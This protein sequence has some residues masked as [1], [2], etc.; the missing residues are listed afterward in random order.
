MLD[1][2]V[3]DRE[4]VPVGR[5]EGQICTKLSA[6]TLPGAIESSYTVPLTPP[7]AAATRA[8]GCGA[9]VAVTTGVTVLPEVSDAL[10]DPANATEAL[11]VR[12]R[13]QAATSPPR[14]TRD[15]RVRAV[16]DAICFCSPEWR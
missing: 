15:A 7:V 16:V 13:P 5:H 9:P 8:F 14:T 12:A 3:F 4:S 2:G 1:E 6:S 10:G 11:R